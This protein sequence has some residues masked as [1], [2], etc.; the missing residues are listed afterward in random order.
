MKEIAEGI[1][2]TNLI[3]ISDVSNNNYR[4]FP[5]LK[6]ALEFFVEIRSDESGQLKPI[7]KNFN[8]VFGAG[9]PPYEFYEAQTLADEIVENNFEDLGIIK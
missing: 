6:D 3:G 5:E 2:Q 9:K 8:S 7:Y 4:N 1:S